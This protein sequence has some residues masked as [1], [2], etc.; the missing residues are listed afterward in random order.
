MQKIHHDN[1]IGC[2]DAIM[3]DNWGYIFMDYCEGGS[4]D[5]YIKT[6]NCSVPETYESIQYIREIL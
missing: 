1:V 3:E 2:R 6:Y 5:Q 4:L